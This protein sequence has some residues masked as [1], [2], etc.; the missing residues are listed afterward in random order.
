MAHALTCCTCPGFLA[1][2]GSRLKL[3][4]AV[5]PPIVYAELSE[6]LPTLRTLSSGEECMQLNLSDNYPPWD[7]L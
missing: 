4:L 6:H 5:A 1:L 3:W 7:K 2:T